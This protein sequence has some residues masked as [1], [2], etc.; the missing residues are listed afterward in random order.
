MDQ[1]SWAIRVKAMRRKLG[2]NQQHFVVLI[3]VQFPRV[4]RWETGSSIPTGLNRLILEF[5]EIVLD[6]QS[7]T[8][9]L[10]TLRNARGEPRALLRARL[11]LSQQSFAELLGVAVMTAN[12]WENGGSAPR[13][14]SALLLEFLA[15]ALNANPAPECS[16]LSITLETSRCPWSAR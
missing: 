10:G 7:P 1:T 6:A 8:V 4:S 3:G 12:R 14:V 2:Q 15:S 5:I 11:G 16:R 13:G 9:V